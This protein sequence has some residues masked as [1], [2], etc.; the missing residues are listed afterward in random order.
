MPEGDRFERSLGPGWSSAFRL[1]RDEASAAEVNDKLIESLARAL[2]TNGGIP[3]LEAITAVVARQH[4]TSPMAVY[5]ALDGIARHHVGHRHT[6]V[7]AEV[8]KSS[9]VL[10][11]LDSGATAPGDMA[12]RVATRVCIALVDHYFFGR[13]REHLITE[14][15]LRDHADAQ[16][17][18]SQTIEAIRPRLEKVARQLLQ[19]PDASGLRAPNRDTPRKSTSDLLR[20]ELGVSPSRVTQ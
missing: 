7:A 18:R 17:W 1:M 16:G 12:Q 10:S 11:G 15:R 8:A 3:G 14:G 9:F 20:E 13:T 4:Q 5:E 2:R 19:S 6:R